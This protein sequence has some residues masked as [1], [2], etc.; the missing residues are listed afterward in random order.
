MLRNIIL[1]R[2]Q[3]VKS[4][5]CLLIIEMFWGLLSVLVDMVRAGWLEINKTMCCTRWLPPVAWAWAQVL[6]NFEADNKAETERTHRQFFPRCSS[7][8]Y[9]KVW[10]TST[11]L[12]VLG[13]KNMSEIFP[14]PKKHVRPARMR[15]PDLM[16]QVWCSYGGDMATPTAIALNSSFNLFLIS[17]ILVGTNGNGRHHVIIGVNHG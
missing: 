2:S 11:E 3:R 8:D 7:S 12:T 13:R 9:S 10:S 17:R 14:A 6:A 1:L 16:L 5:F 4:K 15:T